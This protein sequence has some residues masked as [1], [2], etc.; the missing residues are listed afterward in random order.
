M[1]SFCDLHEIIFDKYVVFVLFDPTVNFSSVSFWN[2]MTF[3]SFR[4]IHM[5]SYGS[6]K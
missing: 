5:I 6:I 3:K 4:L 2:D 1:L